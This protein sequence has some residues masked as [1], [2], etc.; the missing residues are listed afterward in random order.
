[1]AC[2]MVP[3]EGIFEPPRTCLGLWCANRYSTG[4]GKIIGA[5]CFT[6]RPTWSKNMTSGMFCP[7][8]RMRKNSRKGIP[9]TMRQNQLHICLRFTA[10]CRPSFHWAMRSS[11]FCHQRPS[12]WTLHP[13]CPGGTTR[14]LTCFFLFLCQGWE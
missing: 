1:M 2:P 11:F 8:A 9:S 14:F 4:H 5:K 3:K 10:T 7:H 12:L 6:C 13:P